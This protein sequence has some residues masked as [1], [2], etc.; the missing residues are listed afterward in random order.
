MLSLVKARTGPRIT[1]QLNN[2]KMPTPNIKQIYHDALYWATSPKSKDKD[3]HL[4]RT[5]EAI[6][7]KLIHYTKKNEKITYSNE[8]IGEHTFINPEVIRKEIPKLAKKKYISSASTTVL[9]GEE[10]FK[11]RTI[12][13]N[14]ETITNVLN[15]IPQK[16]TESL[17]TEPRPQSE[18]NE[19]ENKNQ[20]PPN[21]I[22]KEPELKKVE[23]SEPDIIEFELTD[24]KANWLLDLV[25]NEDP[26]V[27]IA[28]IEKFDEVALQHAIYGDNGLWE[29]NQDTIENK[30]Q[31]RIYSP[32]GSQCRVYHPTEENYSVRVNIHDLEAYLESKG[33]SFKDFNQSIYNEISHYGLPK[34]E[35]LQQV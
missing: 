21:P 13:I 10:V 35:E 31:W 20:S 5:Q 9:D 26:N 15:D 25:K 19:A 18:N 27:T 23:E 11:R 14:W 32:G 17:P 29:I 34:R 6:L 7:R 22:A 30:Y 24:E 1:R 4:T 33:L 16:E 12:Y 3:Y 8:L 2:E 28:D